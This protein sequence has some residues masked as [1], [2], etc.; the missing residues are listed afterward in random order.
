MAIFSWEFAEIYPALQWLPQIR[1]LR[2]RSPGETDVI[3]Y[4]INSAME[5]A[6]FRLRS[7]SSGSLSL[8]SF[9]SALGRV[10]LAC[11]IASSRNKSLLRR[12]LIPGP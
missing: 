9:L 12:D 11:V 5:R 3:R 4:V 10:V 2:E 1:H 7:F 8:S 6:L